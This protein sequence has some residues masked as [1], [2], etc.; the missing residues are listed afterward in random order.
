[1]AHAID[2]QDV[3]TVYSVASPLVERAREGGG[4]A[5]LLCNTYRYHGHH[6]GDI[7]RTYYRS[8]QEEQQWVQGRDPIKILV[9][10]LLE[11][12]LVKQA[13]LDLIRSDLEKEMD[14]AVQFA[15]DAPYPGPEEVSQ[16]I[17][18]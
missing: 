10:S 17:Y 2:G 13:S 18:A 3:R 1:V 11:Q 9:D 6:V 5:F 14:A 15:V 7:A 8:K 16:D 12:G 4:P